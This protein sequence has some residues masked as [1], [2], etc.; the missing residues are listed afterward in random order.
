MDEI[1]GTQLHEESGY[2]TT[3][4]DDALWHIGAD[5]IEGSGKDDDVK[6]IVDQTSRREGGC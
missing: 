2:D 1:G 6:D 4:E 5:E 3:E